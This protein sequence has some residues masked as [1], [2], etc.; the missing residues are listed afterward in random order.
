LFIRFH[1]KYS[2]FIKGPKE[3]VDPIMVFL[4]ENWSIILMGW[5]SSI[6]AEIGKVFQTAINSVF[7]KVPYEDL[8]VK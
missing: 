4:D 5:K 3:I 6:R 1:T 7:S 8:F 2:D